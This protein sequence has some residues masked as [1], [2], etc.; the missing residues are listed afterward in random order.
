M[1]TLT[2][3]GIEH[4][5]GEEADPLATGAAEAERGHRLRR[6]A[7]EGTEA[8]VLPRPLLLLLNRAV[9]V[10]LRTITSSKKT[11]KK[12]EATGKGS[13][14]I[15]LLLACW[16]CSPLALDIDDDSKVICIGTAAAGAIA[17]ILP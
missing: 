12:R 6:G 15:M 2:L 3:E 16:F 9:P 7:A 1:L 4:P 14:W 13:C 5:Q 10:S 8:E 11:K 17:S